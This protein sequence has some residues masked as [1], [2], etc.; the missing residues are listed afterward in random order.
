MLTA[1][2]VATMLG[3]STNETFLGMAGHIQSPAPNMTIGGDGVIGSG[4]YTTIDNSYNPSPIA[5]SYNPID[6]SSQPVDNSV[7]YP[8][9][10]P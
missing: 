9:A 6:N 3:I 2:A 4:S 1:S 10:A 8:P 7:A 5:D